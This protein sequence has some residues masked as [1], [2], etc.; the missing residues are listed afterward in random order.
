[1][2]PEV[3]NLVQTLIKDAPAGSGRPIF[4]NTKGMPWQRTAGVVRFLNLRKKLDWHGDPVRGKYTC[5]TCRHTFVHRMLS[6]Y[7]TNGVGCS[8]E[9]V[10]ELIGDTPKAAFDHYGREWGQHYQAPLWAAIGER[11]K[12]KS[13]EKSPKVKPRKKVSA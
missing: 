7:W 8:I 11:P 6:G 1:V 10:A 13:G 5:Y 4:R 2:R 3:A 12:P 9:T